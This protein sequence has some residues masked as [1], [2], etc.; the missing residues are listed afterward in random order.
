M[1]YLAMG[2]GDTIAGAGKPRKAHAES[3]KRLQE[4]LTKLEVADALAG[5]GVKRKANQKLSSGQSMSADIDER[6]DS[7]RAI[8]C[9]YGA[10]MRSIIT[11]NNGMRYLP[12][13]DQP[14]Y[15]APRF[16]QPAPALSEIAIRKRLSEVDEPP[17]T[18]VKHSKSERELGSHDEYDMR[19]SH[20]RVPP[21]SGHVS[22][23]LK[24]FA[25]YLDSHPESSLAVS[26]G[27]VTPEARMSR[28][29]QQEEQ[30]AKR[31]ASRM[32]R[33]LRAEKARV[34]YGMSSTEKKE[35]DDRA[36]RLAQQ[37]FDAG[38]LKA[39]KDYKKLSTRV[40]AANLIAAGGQILFMFDVRA[41]DA[42]VPSAWQDHLGQ[43]P[44]STL[45]L[46]SPLAHERS[47]AK[48]AAP[49]V[50]RRCSLSPC[51][52]RTGV[53]KQRTEPPTFGGTGASSAL[54]LLVHD[55]R[56]S[57][58]RA[59]NK[60]HHHSLR[61]S[62]LRCKHFQRPDLREIYNG[63]RVS[64]SF[65]VLRSRLYS[66]HL[67]LAGSQVQGPPESGAVACGS[68][69]FI[70]FLAALVSLQPHRIHHGLLQSFDESLPSQGGMV[71]SDH[72]D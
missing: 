5:M 64:T 40:V 13:G 29:K 42:N 48:R 57:R 50:T 23:N 62:V 36:A 12:N 55:L 4:A 10:S 66:A 9:K 38:Q 22:Y 43:S 39:G 51:C 45:L 59:F 37:A 41:H 2:A 16:G 61:H 19:G 17:P 21:R 65:D 52:A 7:E 25:G 27:V 72:R 60:F 11:M 53:S 24:T 70:L 56:H 46:L 63:P 54:C 28:K 14:K 67:Y 44:Q 8:S 18:P 34:E 6:S 69:V 30:K 49:F 33:Q 68:P 15:V 71:H 20:T 3:H 31:M 1:P 26:A 47:V 32:E 58:F 35:R